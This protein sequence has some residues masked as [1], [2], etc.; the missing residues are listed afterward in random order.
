VRWAIGTGPTRA[1]LRTTSGLPPAQDEI[2]EFA[3]I[4]SNTS[5]V[6]ER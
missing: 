3:L 1:E 4:A 6:A 5:A 2:L